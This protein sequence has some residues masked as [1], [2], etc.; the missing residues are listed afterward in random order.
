MASII[1]FAHTRD[2]LLVSTSI[3]LRIKPLAF[4]MSPS[5][6]AAAYSYDLEH[7][8]TKLR[9]QLLSASN[10]WSLMPG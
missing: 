9:E 10:V 8:T 6:S 1:L 2:D 4:F 7:I 5:S 3:C